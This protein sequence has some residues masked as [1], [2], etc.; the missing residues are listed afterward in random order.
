[1]PDGSGFLYQNLKD[2]KDPY[3]GQVLFHRMGTAVA[4]D[5]VLFRQF[6]KA[7]NEKLATTWGPGGSLSRDG[8]WLT[9]GLLD[10]TR[11]RTTSG[12]PT[13]RSFSQTGKLEK[14]DVSGRAGRHFVRL[15]ST[16]TRS[17]CRPTSARPTAGST[18][19]TCA[20]PAGAAWKPRTVVAERAG[21]AIQSV[22]VAKGLLAVDLPEERLEPD[23]GLRRLGRQV[24][25]A[26]AHAA[27][28]SARPAA[29]GRARSHRGLPQV[30]ELQLSDDASSASISRQPAAA[31]EL[32]E[33]PAG[34]GRSVDRR[35]EAGLVPVEGRHEGQHVRRAQE[36]PRARRRRTRRSSPATAASTSARRRRS[37]PRCSSGSTPAACI[38]LPNLRGGGEYGDAWHEAGML[39]EEAERLRR[40]HRRRRVADRR[41]STPRPAKLAI[42]GGSNGGLLTGA[43][44]DAAARALPRRARRRAA[45]R[46]AALPE[47]PRWRATG[48]PST[49]RPRT[50]TQFALPARLLAVPAREGGHEVSGGA[51]H[52]RRERHARPRAARAQDGGAR[53]RRRR[54]GRAGAKPVLL[55]VDREAG[56]GQGK[57]LNLRSATPP[58][59]GSSSCGSSGCCRRADDSLGQLGPLN[60]QRQYCPLCGR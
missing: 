55:W 26:T 18:P 30:H 54:V 48:C 51:P 46:H 56:H 38:A 19:T 44:V 23:R 16:A 32:W 34:A 5:P 57:P 17:S 2:P 13:S 27:A 25:R 35:G 7:E 1:M 39:G 49:A 60:E 33:Q 58:I 4:K 10:R 21:M 20:Q 40:L 59:S 6:T 24:A 50:P 11:G 14:R 37:P 3:S 43:A 47:L 8:K 15:R 28:A 36:G 29:R 53:C 41:R 22:S 52:R 45:A 31:P 42:A 12:W 9:L